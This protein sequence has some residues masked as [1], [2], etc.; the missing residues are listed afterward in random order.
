M[1]QPQRDCVHSLGPRQAY[2][3]GRLDSIDEGGKSLLDNSLVFFGSSLKD[4]SIHSCEDLP[5]AMFGTLGGRV[6]PRGHVFTAPKTPISHLHR[7]TLGWYG[8]ESE[9]FNDTGAEM[10][11]ELG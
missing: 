9:D 6:R 11:S 4:G 5:I 7:T 1:V 3:L 10:L 2:L 8:I